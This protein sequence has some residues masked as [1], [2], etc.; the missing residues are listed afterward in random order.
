MPKL[1]VHNLSMSV[2]GFVAG[3]DQSLDNPLGAGGTR[4]H[5]WVFE[6]RAGR[7]MIG[8]AGGATG[9][10]DNF[11]TRGEEGIGATI[12]GRNM[13][14]PI[15]GPWAGDP[16]T[17]WWGDEPP[18]H[19]P[20]FVLTHHARDPLPMEGGTTFSFVTDGIEAARQRAFDAAG[21]ADVR[22]GGGASTVQ[23]YLRAGLV[24][25]LHVA[26]VPILLGRG[27]RLFDNLGDSG[28]ADRYEC[29]ELVS[30]AAVAH[31]RFARS[32]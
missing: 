24:D 16:W 23:Q 15:R 12:M 27:E 29:V 7:R 22:L 3:P 28:Y 6:T 25:E 20:V 26:I 13:F 32:R 10:D 5:E 2:D 14:G 31:V 19:H 8:R 21:G 11:L 9:V 17:G 1:R 18:Y 30:S 4:L